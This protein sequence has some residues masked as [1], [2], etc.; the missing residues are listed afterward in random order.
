MTQHARPVIDAVAG[1]ASFYS[2]AGLVM[3]WL[4]VVLGV[5]ASCMS[6]VWLGMQMKDRAERKRRG[7]I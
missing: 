7:E 1:V 4:P 5:I 6:I 3:G 2:L